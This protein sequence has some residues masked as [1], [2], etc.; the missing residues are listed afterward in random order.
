M[1]DVC[2]MPSGYCL[3]QLYPKFRLLSVGML[4]QILAGLGTHTNSKAQHDL[5]QEYRT[6]GYTLALG[7][8]RS[9]YWHRKANSPRWGYV[10]GDDLMLLLKRFQQHLSVPETTI[11]RHIPLCT[12]VHYK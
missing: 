5:S 12:N 11:H 10:S 6:A 8:P 1:F 2:I 4:A 7:D 3:L 9:Y